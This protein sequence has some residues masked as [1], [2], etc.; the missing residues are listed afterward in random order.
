VGDE[1]TPRRRIECGVLQRLAAKRSGLILVSVAADVTVAQLFAWFAR[2][3]EDIARPR[4]R[5][6]LRAGA[7]KRI[8][9]EHT[10]R[11]HP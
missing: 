9:G 7:G 10:T 6:R 8:A 1:T 11:R 4:R 2:Q 5:L 3:N